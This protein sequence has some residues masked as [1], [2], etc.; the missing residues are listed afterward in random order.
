MKSRIVDKM[1]ISIHVSLLDLLIFI[2][3][4]LVEILASAIYLT[5]M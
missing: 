3:V 2:I 4:Q 5:V 1:Y